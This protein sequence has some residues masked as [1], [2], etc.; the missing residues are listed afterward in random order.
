MSGSVNYKCICSDLHACVEA[1]LHCLGMCVSRKGH[2]RDSALVQSDRCARKMDSSTY[3]DLPLLLK[4]TDLSSGI[5][6]IAQGHV[7]V[8]SCI[9]VRKSTR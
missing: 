7:V 9:C 4:T 2:D 3:F 5:Q 1:V 6:A 8:E